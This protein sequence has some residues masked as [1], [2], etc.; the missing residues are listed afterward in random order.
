[1][2]FFANT[3]SKEK[4]GDL[5]SIKTHYCDEACMTEIYIGHST[6]DH[7]EVVGIHTYGRSQV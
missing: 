3:N 7:S 5:T 1:M 6:K 4:C 2:V